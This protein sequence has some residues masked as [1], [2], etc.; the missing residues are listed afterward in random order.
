MTDLH[1]E[2]PRAHHRSPNPRRRVRRSLDFFAAHLQ[3][4]MQLLDLGC[5]PGSITVELADLV[6]PGT[7]TGVD[8]TDPGELPGVTFVRADVRDLPFADGSFD[9][10]LLHGVL[11][12][13]PDPL[14]ALRE[15][16]RVAASG[17]VIGVRDADWDGQ[18]IA[19]PDPA[20]PRTFEILAA[21]RSGTSP[22]VG[23][24]LRGLLHEAGFVDCTASASVDYDG[25]A[26]AA[27][28]TAEAHMAVLS[29]PALTERAVAAG[30]TSAAELA[31]LREAWRR[32]GEQ[33]GAF[34]ARFWC[35]AIGFAD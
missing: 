9:A 16:R 35:E 17:A 7:T 31:E 15:A 18:L 8:Q 27:W 25:T 24:H 1:A 19:P 21:L 11:Q 10:I 23:K 32:W 20:L 30:L 22:R 14:A 3:P 6:V 13:L 33:P 12:H 26:E 34:L 2:A 4:G 5:G 28:S 29:R